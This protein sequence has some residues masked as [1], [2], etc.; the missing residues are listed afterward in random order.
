MKSTVKVLKWVLFIPAAF[1][2][3]LLGEL[4]FKFLMNMVFLPNWLGWL[5]SG[6]VA[7][8][9]FYITGSLVAPQNAKSVNWILKLLMFL[10]FSITFCGSVFFESSENPLHKYHIIQSSASLFVML[11]LLT[12]SVKLTEESKNAV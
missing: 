2:A 9:F 4:L 7:P 1:L 5:I 3:S 6:G 11:C 12:A 10:L 8:V